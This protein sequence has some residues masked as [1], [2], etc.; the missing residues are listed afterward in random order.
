MGHQY[1]PRYANTLTTY[2]LLQLVV[3][4]QLVLVQLALGTFKANASF[5][6]SPVCVS[7]AGTAASLLSSPLAKP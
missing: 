6:G 4:V 7:K 3:L 1:E 2:L 5:A